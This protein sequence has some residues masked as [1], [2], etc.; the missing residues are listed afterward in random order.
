MKVRVLLLTPNFGFGGAEKVFADHSILLREAGCEVKE[1]VFNDT[2][3]TRVYETGNEYF[4][5]N[6]SGGG[7]KIDKILNFFRRIHRLNKVVRDFQPQ[8]VISHLEGADYINLLSKKRC[9]RV[10]VIHGSKVADQNMTGWVGKFRHH[11]LIPY[12]YKKADKI[13][14]VS[15]AL[16][17][18]LHEFYGI[19]HLKMISLPNFFNTSEIRKR[20]AGEIELQEQK[21]FAGNSFKIVAFARLSAQKNLHVL[22]PVISY[23]KRQGHRVQLYLIGDG[24][25]R[26]SLVGQARS[27]GKV[28]TVWDSHL[29]PTADI[30][31]LGYKSNP[32][33]F[34]RFAQLYVLPSLW[35]GFPMALCE[36]MASGIAVM[37]AD[38]PTG[39]REIL[40]KDATKPVIYGLN[41]FGFL[42][43]MIGDVQEEDK[44]Q[45]WGNDIAFLSKDTALMEKLQAVGQARI[46]LYDKAVLGPKWVQAYIN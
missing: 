25:L 10:I 23:L 1:C 11:V 17:D 4:T 9:K 29:D 2:D 5:L 15:K 18:E 26:D 3:K 46:Q 37:A 8:V 33:A 34:L 6:V 20:A 19:D 31:F 36:A 12:I 21:L 30:F 41:D 39:P 40:V 16:K 43:P 44:I 35:E 28:S 38:C 45:S 14:T 24:D 32:H 7:N 42:M 22:F 13:I 27:H